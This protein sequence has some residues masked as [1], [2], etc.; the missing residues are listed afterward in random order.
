MLLKPCH[1]CLARHFVSDVRVRVFEIRI[2]D[3]LI[4]VTHSLKMDFKRASI[5]LWLLITFVAMWA[6]LMIRV[7]KF[8]VSR[9]KMS[10]CRGQEGIHSLPSSP[11]N[12]Y[13]FRL[14]QEMS[15]VWDVKQ[16]SAAG[17]V[18]G[19]TLNRARIL[20]ISIGT[21]VLV[22]KWSERFELCICFTPII[23]YLS[24][25]YMGLTLGLL[26]KPP[27]LGCINLLFLN[28]PSTAV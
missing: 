4:H 22:G 6:K 5:I 3:L 16:H 11:G 15:S 17:K 21:L 1:C 7:I 8:H 28:G 24:S 2:S 10:N 14:V 18:Q 13:L 20:F 9:H 25:Q 12:N 27:E 23:S 26:L 19:L